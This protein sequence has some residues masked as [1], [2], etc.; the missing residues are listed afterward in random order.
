MSIIIIGK[1]PESSDWHDFLYIIHVYTFSY[2]TLCVQT[3]MFYMTYNLMLS[4]YYACQVHVHVAVAVARHQFLHSSSS[5]LLCTYI[6][7]HSQ[8]LHI[9]ILYSVHCIYVVHVVV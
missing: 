4:L 6:I 8:S 5:L 1:L 2:P 3:V 9:I 7:A